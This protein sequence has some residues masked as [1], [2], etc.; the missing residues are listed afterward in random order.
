MEA[1]AV[2]LCEDS[3]NKTELFLSRPHKKVLSKLAGYGYHVCVL[4]PQPP[5]QHTK[6]TALLTKDVLLLP[7]SWLESFHST[8]TGTMDK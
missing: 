2:I 7:I 1:Q 6:V 8:Q 4:I 3:Q 5:E